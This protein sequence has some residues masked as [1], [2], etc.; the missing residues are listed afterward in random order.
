[1][2]E[3]REGGGCEV[4]GEVLEQE[5]EEEERE[6]RL[7]GAKGTFLKQGDENL[8]IDSIYSFI[9]SCCLFT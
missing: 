3:A 8:D 9:P 4:M 6:R 1:M 5:D 7:S 2:T